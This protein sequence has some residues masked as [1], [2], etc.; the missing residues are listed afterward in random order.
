MAKT[1]PS[2][3]HPSCGCCWYHHPRRTGGTGTGTKPAAFVRALLLLFVTA[4]LG[5]SLLR[6]RGWQPPVALRLRF[7]ENNNN[8]HHGGGGGGGSAGRS[9]PIRN[10]RESSAAFTTG[11]VDRFVTKRSGPGWEVWDRRTVLGNGGAAVVANNNNNNNSSEGAA[12]GAEPCRWHEYKAVGGRLPPNAP[13][14]F[15]CLY[16]PEIDGWV[17]KNIQN[18]GR[19]VSC[20]PLTDLLLLSNSEENEKKNN[21][22]E[23]VYMDIGANIGACVIQIL[24]TTNASVVAFEPNPNNL[25]RLTSTLL[26]LPEEMK[27]RV[28]LFPVAVGSEMASSARIVAKGDNQGNTQVMHAALSR[29]VAKGV[30]GADNPAGTVSVER[31]DD[32][33]SK[34]LRVD[35]IKY[36]LSCACVVSCRVASRMDSHLTCATPPLLSTFPLVGWTSK[37]SSASCLRGWATSSAVR[38]R[39]TLRSRSSCWDASRKRRRRRARARARR[40]RRRGRRR[41]R[42][43]RARG[44]SWCGRSSGPGSWS[45]APKTTCPAGAT[46]SSGTS[47]SP[48]RT[49]SAS[50]GLL[51]LVVV[52]VVVRG[53]TGKTKEVSLAAAA[54]I[55][56]GVRRAPSNRSGTTPRVVPRPGSVVGQAAETRPTYFLAIP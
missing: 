56:N 11:G 7:D 55:S 34:E 13:P 6:L 20:D 10:N 14:V 15:M 42:S 53:S 30:D 36:G 28:T 31:M 54:A 19:W 21:E 4:G 8:H 9:G 38:A 41:G 51:L 23:L 26:N 39:S 16:P 12:A 33:L 22:N 52:V 27:N 43:P 47:R 32:L 48:S 29:D 1:H 37:A 24:S 50:G 40:H 3:P 18:D 44:R 35:L 2:Q 17:S 45:T 49:W 5:G 25:F 46:L